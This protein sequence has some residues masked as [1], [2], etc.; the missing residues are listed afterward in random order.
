VHAQAVSFNTAFC[1]GDP[2]G[3]P[4]CGAE[5]RIGKA[6]HAG[7]FLKV[8]IV[9]REQGDHK[10]R[11]CIIPAAARIHGYQVATNAKNSVLATAP[12]PLCHATLTRLIRQMHGA[13]DLTAYVRSR[14]Q[15][16]YVAEM[17]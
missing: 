16:S 10:G 8:L 2:C 14:V 9:R 7:T 6:R 15:Q 13:W 11:P 3:R 1:R 4:I 5:D 12:R 17:D